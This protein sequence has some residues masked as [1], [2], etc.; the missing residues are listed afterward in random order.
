MVPDEAPYPVD[1]VVDY[2]ASVTDDSFTEFDVVVTTSSTVADG[3]VD[4]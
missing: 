3:K 1:A 2:T 4:I